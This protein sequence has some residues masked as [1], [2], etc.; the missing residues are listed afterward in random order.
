[1]IVAEC[2]TPGAGMSNSAVFGCHTNKF[3]WFVNVA[4]VG[5]L[6]K[7]PVELGVFAQTRGQ[8][9]C[10]KLRR[11]V[12]EYLRKAAQSSRGIHPTAGDEQ[13]HKPVVQPELNPGRVHLPLLFGG[14]R[15]DRFK[16]LHDLPKSR[17]VLCQTGQ[18]AFQ[19]IAAMLPPFSF[20]LMR[21]VPPHVAA[22]DSR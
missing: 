19:N 18:E 20:R 9:A 4:G 13:R 7:L 1:M 22:F 14:Q 16:D 3:C 15:K 6:G 11:H 10:L 5:R 21:S 2:C 17:E 8:A 12:R